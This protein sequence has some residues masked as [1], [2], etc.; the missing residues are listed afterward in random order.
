MPDINVEGIHHGI[1][2][3]AYHSNLCPGPS[4]SAST[5]IQLDQRSPAYA[6]ARWYGHP[7]PVESEDTEATAFGSAA[8]CYI[9]EGP[10][11]FGERYVVRPADY[12]G[13]TKAGKEFREAHAAWKQIDRGDFEAILAMAAAVKAHPS[14]RVAF[15]GGKAEATLICQD[16]ETGLW[17]KA[18]PDYL[19][20][21]L[22]LNYKTTANG[23]REPWERQATSLGYYVSAAMCIDVMQANG[24]E[25]PRYGFV[26]QEKEPPYSV[27]VRVFDAAA[28][29][30][31][32]L[33]YRRALHD[34]ARCLKSGIWPGYGDGVE[35][36]T[37]P[38]WAERTL[39]KRHEAGDFA[40]MNPL[41]AG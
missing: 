12:D 17:L 18:R 2:F 13:R 38:T 27:V 14:A 19:K 31:G 24:M 32:R 41:M 36:V 29:E 22:A 37:I 39:E 6:Y 25:A 11:V 20:G 4:V 7:A 26:V 40:T 10:A 15:V 33:Q 21:Q 28:I 5:L 30:W 1:S 16:A 34:F 23:K 8:H 3:A 35:T 9:L